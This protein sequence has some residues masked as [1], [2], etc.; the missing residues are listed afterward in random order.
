MF[1]AKSD[2]EQSI[3][4]L[5]SRGEAPNAIVQLAGDASNRSFFR[6]FYPNRLSAVAM[7]YHDAGI[8][9]EESFLEIQRFLKDLGL[10]VP[11]IYNHFR[12]DRVVLLEDLGD[13]LL[14]KVVERSD[15]TQCGW[16]LPAG[17]GSATDATQGYHEAQFRLPGLQLSF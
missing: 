9:D 5:L 8:G 7:A 17:R 3:L 10:P 1:E 15:K 4:K 11:A 16:A 2:I 13:D 6:V 12:E 14:E